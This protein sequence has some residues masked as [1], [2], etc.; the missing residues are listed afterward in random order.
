MLGEKD[1]YPGFNY[2]MHQQY[3]DGTCY[4]I[5]YNNTFT[6]S[7]NNYFTSF[8]TLKKLVGTMTGIKAVSGREAWVFGKNYAAVFKDKKLDTIIQFPFDISFINNQYFTDSV[9]IFTTEDKHLVSYL[10]DGIKLQQLGNT[11]Q[12]YIPYDE[13][14][15]FSEVKK[16]FYCK[17]V[18]HGVELL[19]YNNKSN[20]FDVLKTISL[21]D[22]SYILFFK[23]EEHFL[24]SSLAYPDKGYWYAAGKI[25]PQSY[26]IY[27]GKDNTLRLWGNAEAEPYHIYKEQGEQYSIAYFN[28]DGLKKTVRFSMADKTVSIEAM[29]DG[30]FFSK[31]SNRAYRIFSTVKKYPK[32]FKGNNASAIF[33]VR[34]DDAGR[35]WAG[36]YQGYLAV[37]DKEGVRQ[38]NES[39][40]DYT[41]GGSY[42]NQHMYMVGEGSGSLLQFDK[43]GNCKQIQPATYTG[44]STYVSN[45]KKYFYF[46]KPTGAGLWQ[47]TTQSLETLH[48]VWN[49][50]DSSK[51]SRVFNILTIA[52]DTAGRIWYGA[53][54][55]AL[56][57][58]NPA[59]DKATTWQTA[60]NETP[61]GAFSS[62]VDKHG[63][64]WIGSS[65]KGI[66]YYSD[67][68]K[69]AVPSSFKKIVHPFL[70]GH[71]TISALTICG[72]WLVIAATDKMLL[73]HIDSLYYSNKTIVRYLNPQEAA[74]TAPTEQNT[75][76]TSH[77]DSTVWFSTNDMLY[78][79]DVKKW[80]KAPV[81]LVK[82]TA[83]IVAK[84]KEFVLTNM[85]PMRF[86]AGFNSFE[87][88]FHYLSP[89]NLP[90]YISAVLVMDG[91][92]GVMPEPDLQSSFIYKNLASG[93][94]FFMVDVFETDGSITHYSYPL[95][96]KKFL[97]QQW[98]FWAGISFTSL[99]FLS[100]LIY[101][102]RKKEIAEQFVKL[103]EAELHTY[104]SEQ[105]KKL[106]KLQLV[107][108]SSQ[109]RPHFILNALNAIGAEMDDKPTAESVLSRLGESVNLIF[110]HAQQ[111]KVLHPFANEWELVK[112]VIHIHRMMYLK[113]VI[114]NLPSDE[115]VASIQHL[116]LPLGLLQ[117]PVENALLHGLS[118]RLQSPWLLTISIQENE[119][120]VII[121][122][123]DNG[124]GRRKSATLSNFTKHGTGTK[125][126]HDIIQIIND[127]NTQ[128]ISISYK[129]DIFE[130]NG[131]G[132]GTTVL[133]DIPK[134]LLYDN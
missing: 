48:P 81:F 75:L 31:T 4:F 86:E 128:K 116:Q 69:P 28:K 112:N 100:Y 2:S 97:W 3:K 109:F 37:I 84:E 55:Q 71:K 46:G 54:K 10:F 27:H 57:M 90:R 105:E 23:D 5:E 32:I 106:A 35:I 74:F 99:S 108:L 117:I 73:L 14:P 11:G 43:M 115:T 44:F 22:F 77:T 89:D 79:W 78:Q 19:V 29:P 88:Q 131:E 133:I 129:D 8:D 41:N 50:I 67:Y 63:T 59:T 93:N 72:D 82:P 33:S 118:N 120:N 51:G 58:Y 85:Q 53:G 47:T 95:V 134:Q 52:E 126:L 98:W 42:Y 65:T 9:L 40:F 110:N 101:T 21:E 125:N 36:S 103:K 39:R 114:T 24:F 25:A 13:G 111:Q 102:K 123:T 60:K 45:N 18:E 15:I 121:S 76:I 26:S 124:V 113:E 132:Y 6:I 122:I 62:A 107:T 92:K 130:M 119:K 30:N 17:K 96:L 87:I 83:I 91:E 104:K 68:T 66:W 64:V 12:R 80:L 61:F 49:K 56:A 16:L 20:Q 34:Q 127:A 38:I 7:G 1:G 70:T 94:Y